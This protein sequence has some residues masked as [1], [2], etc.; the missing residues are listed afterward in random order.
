MR[1]PVGEWRGR[2]E[3]REWREE[4]VKGGERGGRR[5]EADG[6]GKEEGG[7]GREQEREG[8][9]HLLKLK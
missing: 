4:E 9:D 1:E 8:V 7:G 2:G 3:W 6:R 5:E